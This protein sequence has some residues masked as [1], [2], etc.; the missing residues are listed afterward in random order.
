MK[1]LSTIF[2]LGICSLAFVACNEE[3]PAPDAQKCTTSTVLANN[4]KRAFRMGFSTWAYG[5]ETSAKNDT[6]AYIAAN[7]DIYSEQIDDKIPWQAL[8]NDTAFPQAFLDD[9]ENRISKKPAGHQ[10]L[11]GVGLFNT[12]RTNLAEDYDGSTP[13]YTSLNDAKIVAAYLKYVTWLIEKYQPDYLLLALE[14]NEIWINNQSLWAGYTQMMQSIRT[15]LKQV[16]PNLLVSESMTLHNLYQP[17]VID[18]VVYQQTMINYL[19]QLDFAA[20]SFY[21]FFKAFSNKNQFQEAFDFL[22]QNINTPIAFAETNHLAEDLVIASTNTNLKGDECQQN[23]YLEVLLTN[24]QEQRYRF[25]IW[26]AY[27]DYDQLWATFPE[28]LKDIG[29]IWR[30]TGLL[31]ESGQERTSAKTWKIVF[32]H[33]L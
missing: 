11:L 26:W 2:L 18:V 16:Y 3:N 9:M 28:E 23:E 15:S 20:I 24:A 7:A 31:D 22:H 17:Q 10:L 13:S 19:N 4:A 21:P 32:G 33:I 25:V 14:S 27:R 5:A 12:G 1:S 29:K 8:F 6:Y 30:D